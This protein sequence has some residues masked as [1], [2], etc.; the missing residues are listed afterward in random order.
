MSFISC[1][2]LPTS[3]STHLRQAGNEV[4]GVGGACG[5]L[6]A[7]LA[8]VVLLRAPVCD[9]VADRHRKQHRL[10]APRESQVTR[11]KLQSYEGRDIANSTGSCAPPPGSHKSHV[12][13]HTPLSRAVQDYCRDS[14][15]RRGRGGEREEKGEGGVHSER[16]G[17]TK[18][19]VKESREG[20][21]SHLTDERHCLRPVPPL[22]STDVPASQ[23]Q[24]P[25]HRLHN[26]RT[27]E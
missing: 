19:R 27:S 14:L 21:G 8:D 22:K 20:P 4:V 12:T 15:S 3:L 10:P 26:A 17:E 6:D 24:P 2:Y 16:E 18:E 7:L 11:R 23:M 5:G 25:L 1:R 9:V 13:S